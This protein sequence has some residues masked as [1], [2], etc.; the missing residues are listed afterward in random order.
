MHTYIS[1]AQQQLANKSLTRNRHV[2]NSLA[3]AGKHFINFEDNLIMLAVCWP[4]DGR[5]LAV[6]RSLVN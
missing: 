2:A 1:E 5:L 6:C 3:A 4:F